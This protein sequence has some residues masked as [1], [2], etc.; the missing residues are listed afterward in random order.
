VPWCRESSNERLT[1]RQAVIDR[2]ECGEAAS[3]AIKACAKGIRGCE[4]LKKVSYCGND[5]GCCWESRFRG[6]RE[7]K[8]V[9]TTILRKHSAK[10]NGIAND[11]FTDN[12]DSP[13]RFH[14]LSVSNESSFF[15]LENV[16]SLG[17]RDCH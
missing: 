5:C 17:I 10:V 14:L 12:T 1:L 9:S 7:A 4:E 13:P 15:V 2:N 16:R 8:K 6:R 3:E 11:N